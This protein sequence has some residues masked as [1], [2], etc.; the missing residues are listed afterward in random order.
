MFNYPVN[1]VFH[2][3]NLKQTHE[4]SSIYMLNPKPLNS[5]TTI[6]LYSHPGEYPSES[7]YLSNR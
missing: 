4:I 7:S 6:T 3:L 5:D 2:A 1:W